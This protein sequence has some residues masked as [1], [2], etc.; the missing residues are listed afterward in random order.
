M[1]INQD[2]LGW[3]SIDST[4]IDYPIVKG[5]D[6]EFYLNHNFYKEADFAGAIFMDYRNSVDQLDKHTI[7]YGHDMKDGSMFGSLEKYADSD[8]WN[9][10]KWIEWEFRGEIY[11]WEIFSAY[12]TNDTSW[13]EMEFKDNEFTDFLRDIQDQSNFSHHVELTEEDRILTLSTCTV[14][15]TATERFIVHARLIEK[16]EKSER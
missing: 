6:N 5:V 2:Y 8:Y 4:P 15:S 16:S 11:L 7:I 14:N 12:V 10:H 3:L 13:M 9:K 1:Q